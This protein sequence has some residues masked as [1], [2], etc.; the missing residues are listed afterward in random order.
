[1]PNLMS[2]HLF[3]DGRDLMVKCILTKDIKIN[4]YEKE[5]SK[6]NNV[7]GMGFHEINQM[8]QPDKYKLV[9]SYISYIKKNEQEKKFYR[10]T[11]LH[12]DVSYAYRILDLVTQSFLKEEVIN[13]QEYQ[14]AYGMISEYEYR[15]EL[16]HS[17][18]E[19]RETYKNGVRIE[20]WVKETENNGKVTE[21]Y[22]KEDGVAKVAPTPGINYH[23]SEFDVGDVVEKAIHVQVRSI[24][25]LRRIK[26]LDWIDSL[27][28][29][30]SMEIVDTIEG[31]KAKVQEILKD[32][33]KINEKKIYYDT[34]GTGLNI[35]NLPPDHEDFD[36]MAVHVLSWVCERREDGYPLK[37][38]SIAIP[39]GM[40]YC[41]NV[42]ELECAE[43]LKPLLVNPSIGVVS[44]NCDYEIQICLRYSEIEGE[45]SYNEYYK[46][47]KQLEARI[48]GIDEEYLRSRLLELEGRYKEESK[49]L[50][51]MMAKLKLSGLNKEIEEIKKTLNAKEEFN[52]VRELP[53]EQ[54][55]YLSK[56]KGEDIYR[57]N[58]KYDTLVLSRMVN[59]GGVMKDGV[60]PFKRHNIDVLSE[61]YLGLQKLSLDDIFGNS[62]SSKF[63]IYDFS[64]LPREFLL[65]YACPDT[66]VM[67]FIEWH[68]ER[69]VYNN[70]L[71][72]GHS[73]EQARIANIELLNLY[74]NVD[75]PFAAHM[76]EFA[77]YKGIAIDKEQLDQ[78]KYKEESARDALEKFLGDITGEEIQWTSEKQIKPLIF[79]KYR[80]PVL[81]YTSK[82]EP[83]YNK[84]TRKLHIKQTKEKHESRYD[85]VVPIP[86]IKEDLT[87]DVV[88]PDGSVVKEVLIKKDVINNLQCPIS[89]VYQEYMNRF[90]DLTSFT[91][92]IYE[93]TF[94]VNGE[95]IYFPSYKS[96]S[97]DTGRAAGGI[98]IMK[99]SIKD[100]FKARKN[101]I[102]IGGDLDAA[103]LR[104]IATMSGD[105]EEINNFKDPRYDP[106][107]RTASQVNNVPVPEVTSEQRSAAKV[108][109][110]GYAYGMGAQA[111]AENIY[112]DLVPVPEP[113][114][115]KTGLLLK[116][117]DRKNPIKS[118]WLNNLRAMTVKLGYSKTPMGR[119][120]W[121]PEVKYPKTEHWKLAKSGRQG[122]NVPIQGLCA[123]F[124][125]QRLVNIFNVIKEC[126]ISRFFTQPI[127]VHD[128]FFAE[129]NMTLFQGENKV[130]FNEDVKREQK[131][132]LFWLYNLMYSEITEKGLNI[133]YLEDEAPMTMGIGAGSTWNQAKSDLYGCPQEL[134]KE[135][136]M[137]YRKNEISDE[138]HEQLKLNPKETMLHLIRT[139]WA[140]QVLIELKK[141]G[142][143]PT[144][145]PPKVDTIFEDLFIRRSLK[146]IFP[147]DEK[148]L[149]DLGLDNKDFFTG[150]VIKALKYLNKED[151]SVI[152]ILNSDSD[153]LRLDSNEDDLD[154][155]EDNIVDLET[156]RR[157]REEYEK[158]YAEDK[159]SYDCLFKESSL[160]DLEYLM[161]N[162][163]DKTLE[164]NIHGMLQ[165]N[166]AKLEKLIKSYDGKGIYQVVVFGRT[167]VLERPYK[168]I[169]TTYKVP[170]TEELILKIRTLFEENKKEAEK[171]E[172]I[173]ANKAQ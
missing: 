30:G 131:A 42:D 144:K 16:T 67:P 93:R 20:L 147:V 100:M 112:P 117:Y 80:Y 76:A 43:A 70:M 96:T 142:V 110:F 63:K 139:W 134:Q 113:L 130:Y 25:S 116:E 15:K 51:P 101:H 120:K 60:T 10:E 129:V 45:L 11:L 66:Y 72:L 138:L 173:L 44:H 143:D 2:G 164:I 114:V 49:G 90:K 152:E 103:E 12:G 17:V 87:I 8:L 36:M 24:Q 118:S 31:V 153:D 148:Y 33:E 111:A 82:N 19:Q 48:E 91:K 50:T 125:K 128:E 172:K 13:K 64:V 69:Q 54:K 102:L 160:L 135:L 126:N 18:I 58:I 162:E 35:F 167:S 140:E 105:K 71:A 170:V 78:H 68:L 98:M 86:E 163:E 14:S 7:L 29:E 59:N 84:T 65:Y 132:N 115:F 169:P 21:I 28:Q 146:D 40:K 165:S 151:L 104:L 161:T 106:H 145:I 137:K 32:L 26:N 52:R 85:N 61:E 150:Q 62:K 46:W 53:K 133:S 123:D 83:S 27:I 55:P 122:G 92:M 95:W 79:A 57:L 23:K 1:M 74:Y 5:K 109:N 141:I 97:T 89:Y 156:F 34:E 108:I 94:L 157:M 99:K 39:V 171:I 9:G 158:S 77:N 22:L 6:V 41:Q 154:E 121:F 37:V 136:I 168:V 3:I 155:D 47:K 124:I 119:Y 75:V 159:Y 38:K 149:V 56:I 127:F 81:Y 73:E 166:V 4:I 107:T 88:Q